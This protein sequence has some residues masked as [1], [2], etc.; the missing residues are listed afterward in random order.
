MEIGNKFAYQ[1]TLLPKRLARDKSKRQLKWQF[2]Q[3]PLTGT[4]SFTPANTKEAIQLAKSST[5]IEPDRMSTQ[6][7]K[8]LDH[9]AINYFTNIFNLSNSTGQIPEI[10]HKSIIILILKPGKDNNIGMNWRPISL[11]WPAAKTLE[12]L[13][14]VK[15]LTHI[16]L[17]PAQ[18]GIRTK[19]STCTPTATITVDIAAGFS[20]KK[21]ANRTVLVTL[22]L[23]SAFGNVNHQKLLDCVYN[24]NIP[25]TMKTCENM[26]GTK[27]S[28]VFSALQLPSGRRSNTASEHQADQVRKG[29]YQ[30]HIRAS[31][32]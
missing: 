29:H 17:H 10:W 26:S 21:P 16:P 5:A 24:T 1:F 27:R 19:H 12:K 8:R 13:L 2:H 20:R 3:L 9:G 18:H 7:L 32:G 23:T 31:G 4:P 28:S 11:L 30:L 22:D 14:L 25:A 6:Y 15:I